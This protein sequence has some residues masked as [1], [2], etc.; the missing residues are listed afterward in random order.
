[1]KVVWGD[2]YGSACCQLGTLGGGNHFIEIQKDTQDNVWAMIHCGSRNLGYKVAKYYNEVAQQL[3]GAFY[4]NTPKDLAFLPSCVVEFE[5]YLIEHHYCLMFA[6][7]NRMAILC[8]TIEAL[9]RVL[10]SYKFETRDTW[11][12]FYDVHH[13]Y[14]E[15]MGNNVYLHRKGATSAKEGQIGLIP[16]SQGTKSY[17]VEGLGNKDSFCSCSHGAGRTMSRTQA[18]KELDLQKE[19]ESMGDIIHSIHTE[20][21]LDEA[22]SAYKDIDEVMR[23]QSNLVKIKETLK[24]LAVIKG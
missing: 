24:P 2:E 13:N 12:N 20:K 5:N 21:D 23:N 7:A 3:N 9:E 11:S 16:G 22:P 18:K 17:L 4:T 6:K 14:I 10:P 15:R 1:M 19:I 8:K